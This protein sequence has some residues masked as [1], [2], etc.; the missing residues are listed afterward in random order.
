MRPFF[1]D[2]AGNLALRER[3]GNDIVSGTLGQAFILSGPEGSGRRTFA[4]AIAMALCCARLEDPSC[5]LPCGS[6]LHCRQIREDISPDLYYIR[7]EDKKATIG[8]DAIRAIRPSLLMTP[9]SNP[10]KV[11][12]FEEADLLTPEAQNALLLTLENP[13][14]YA[15]FLLLCESPEQLLQTIRSRAPLLRMEH[16]DKA[17]VTEYLLAHSAE[18]RTLIRSDP[19]A[20]D[21]TILRADGCIGEVL[22]HL[23]AKS[24]TALNTQRERTFSFLNALTAHRAQASVELL[25]AMGTDRSAMLS[26]F[27]LFEEALRDCILIRHTDDPVLSFFVSFDEALQYTG[28]ASESLFLRALDATHTASESL[29]AN[30]NVRLTLHIWAMD[31]GLL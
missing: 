3:I 25:K 6:C 13:P 21:A 16:L 29:L 2:I 20:L 4:K 19:G 1:T 7:R 9:V 17:T 24:R 5:P 26:L 15:L 30:A 12:I 31:C 27:S 11:Y 22:S 28:H 14:P 18:A 23:D 10:V 8:V